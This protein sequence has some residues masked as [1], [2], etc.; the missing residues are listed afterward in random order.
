MMVDT[1]VE[2]FGGRH[3]GRIE[4]SSEKIESTNIISFSYSCGDYSSHT[5]YGF[6]LSCKKE[7]NK[8]HITSTGGNGN[9]R[10]GSLFKLNYYSDN[11]DFLK[12]L[13]D[14]IIEYQL[15]LN[16]GYTVYVDGLPWGYGDS[17]E[18]LYDSEE[19][20]YKSSNQSPMISD[21]ARSAI[22][23]LFLKEALNNN[24]DFNSEKSN[25]QLYDDATV[26]FLQ[27]RWKGTHFGDNILVEFNDNNIK[28]YVNDK[29]TDDSTYIIYEGNIRQDKLVEENPTTI[30]EH[31]YLEFNGISCLKKKNKILLTAYFMKDGYSTCNLLIQKS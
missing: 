25:V 15:S 11:L 24:L 30:N 8:L 23:T 14:L 22:Y 1:E 10:D 6:S 20:I 21:D 5:R 28:I 7:D 17:L 31:S 26:E 29:L 4:G 18:V 9:K 27:G 16:N 19:K 12:K 2:V 3:E 13:N